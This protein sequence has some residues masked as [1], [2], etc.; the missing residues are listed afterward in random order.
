MFRS[1]ATRSVSY[2]SFCE[3]NGSL[4]DI[5][6]S[7]GLH[8]VKLYKR[9]LQ[10]NSPSYEYLCMMTDIF[11]R[12]KIQ[13]SRGATPCIT[14]WQLSISALIALWNDV[15]S[16]CGVKYVCTRKLNQDP[17]ENYFSFIR[18]KGGF[19]ANLDPKQFADAYKQVLI[20][21][22]ISQSELSNCESDTNLLLLEVFGTPSKQCA[23]YTS[24]IAT[25]D[26][27]GITELA[28]ID[29]NSLSQQDAVLCWRIYL[30]ELSCETQLQRVYFVIDM[31]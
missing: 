14:G 3:K 17:L 18:A 24:V 2:G 13:G 29:V 11:K 7:T 8:D 4:F 31:L 19:S 21:S 9:A 28:A 30:Q 26:A 10:D 15:K 20:K 27:L 23:N 12:L 6:N 1:F 5:F 16:V 25:D 22:F